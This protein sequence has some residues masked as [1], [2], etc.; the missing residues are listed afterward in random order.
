M[1]E[2]GNG[3]ETIMGAVTLAKLGDDVRED[4]PGVGMNSGTGALQFIGGMPTR[5]I[6]GPLLLVAGMRVNL[7]ES[8]RVPGPRRVKA[9]AVAIERDGFRDAGETVPSYRGVVITEDGDEYP[10]GPRGDM[11]SVR[12]A[13]LR[14]A[15]ESGTFRRIARMS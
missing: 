3:E 15:V 2:N 5:K 13:W 10:T 7:P 6:D 1:D 14:L 4:F 8:V 11:E 12:L 9:V